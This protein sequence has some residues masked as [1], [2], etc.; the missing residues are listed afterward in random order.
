MNPTTTVDCFLAPAAHSGDTLWDSFDLAVGGRRIEVVALSDGDSITGVSFGPSIVDPERIGACSRD[1]SALSAVREQ[2]RAYAAGE[3]DDFDLRLRPY[4]TPFQLAV[5]GALMSIP[6]GATKS[7]GEVASS[8]G[9]P[10]AARAIGSAVGANPIA[11]VIPC[12][13]VI[14]ADGSLTGYGGGI[15]AK[16]S[17]LSLEGSLPFVVRV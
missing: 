16:M 8:I 14:G 3:L 5:W 17:L 2:L 10:G 13:R 7:Y 1:P 15:D 9:R 6:F 11:I 12:H 4:G